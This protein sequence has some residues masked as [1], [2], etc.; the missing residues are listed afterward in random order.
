MINY[1]A[2]TDK[3]HKLLDYLSILEYCQQGQLENVIRCISNYPE[4]LYARD[5]VSSTLYIYYI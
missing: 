2:Y 4:L 3:T 5:V 1:T